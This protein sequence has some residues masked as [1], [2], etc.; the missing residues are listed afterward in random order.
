LIP[1]QKKHK[2]KMAAAYRWAETLP[3][4]TQKTLCEDIEAHGGIELLIGTEKALFHLL[5]HLVKTEPL[6]KAL[7]K[8]AGD[9]IRR[10]IQTKVYT[11]QKHWKDG[12]YEH[13]ILN[14]F[15]IVAASD[16][17]KILQYPKD[18]VQQQQQ[19]QQQPQQKKK[20]VAATAPVTNDQWISPPPV[21]LSVERELLIPTK[22][23]FETPPIIHRPAPAA[24]DDILAQ[25]FTK[26]KVQDLYQFE[27]SEKSPHPELE[28][29][30]TGVVFANTLYP[31]LNMVFDAV[32]PIQDIEG[33][34]GNSHYHGFSI[35]QEVE[36]RWILDHEDG[37]E[38]YRC[39]I[40]A[41]N[42]LQF[43]L[44]GPIYTLLFNRANLEHFKADYKSG[45][46]DDLHR[47]ADDLNMDD[48]K[49]TRKWKKYL[50]VFPDFVQLSAKEI[51]NHAA[52]GY[53]NTSEIIPEVCNHQYTHPQLQ[54]QEVTKH[55]IFW[56]VA[57]LDVMIYKKNK[58]ETRKKGSR[59]KT[60]FSSPGGM[61]SPP[62]PAART[63]QDDNHTHPS[64]HPFDGFSTSSFSR[65]PPPT[66]A[67]MPPPAAA[68]S[69]HA[70]PDPTHSYAA[71]MDFDF[72]DA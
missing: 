30:R 33:V 44:P 23:S 43:T 7:Y 36:Y 65:K 48:G 12:S 52:E 27:T 10:K 11:W 4:H 42:V 55:F 57:R 15:G 38:P 58:V 21:E 41:P 13:K 45:I 16:R 9:P 54:G 39:E 19:E 32:H 67:A 56:K 69:H 34:D 49:S 2:Q 37:P 62:P 51:H 8:E 53:K 59:L 20:R 17:K 47:L 26:M 64:K 50:L 6:K 35:M 18:G 22:L 60:A 24:V 14:K 31:E 28:S 66:Y 40:V 61:S 72:D 1:T 71:S 68:Q 29:S 5:N 25:A 46:D 70:T 3:Q 63:N